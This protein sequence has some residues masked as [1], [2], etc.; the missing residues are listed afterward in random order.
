MHRTSKAAAA[1]HRASRR[2]LLYSRS[3]SPRARQGKRARRE[4]GPTAAQ[5]PGK[6]GR[7]PEPDR[8][9][10]NRT[11][12]KRQPSEA[13]KGSGH[14]RTGRRAEA[15]GRDTEAR[16]RRRQSTPNPH[17]ET[18]AGAPSKLTASGAAAG[19]ASMCLAQHFRKGAAQYTGIGF[20]LTA[21]ISCCGTSFV[22]PSVIHVIMHKNG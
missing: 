13:G 8:D 2:L 18:S 5:H 9:P 17:T 20:F 3:G 10:G 21:V 1:A 7:R 16:G 11:E 14:P 19:G 6:P 12:R 15:A 22:N 4:P